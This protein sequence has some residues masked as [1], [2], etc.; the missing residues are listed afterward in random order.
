RDYINQ[1]ADPIDPQIIADR[2]GFVDYVI[3]S[4]SA[5]REKKTVWKSWL[6][7][8]AGHD[9]KKQ[10]AIKR[11]VTFH[12]DPIGCKK[13]LD[14]SNLDL[15][16]W[17]RGLEFLTDLEELDLS[18]NLISK[19]PQ[20]INQLINLGGLDL[21][22]NRLH[23]LPNA[24]GELTFLKILDLCDNPITELPDE[25]A[26]LAH[27]EYLSLVNTE[28]TDLPIHLSLLK[29][30]EIIVN[31]DLLFT[32]ASRKHPVGFLFLPK[33]CEVS[34]SE[35]K[36]IITE[37]IGLWS[38]DWIASS[39]AAT[40]FG[41]LAQLALNIRISVIDESRH[42]ARRLDRASDIVNEIYITAL[43]RH[44]NI[45]R[46]SHSGSR[47]PLNDI[48]KLIN[49]PKFDRLSDSAI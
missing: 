4:S 35:M 2:I 41:A 37:G 16:E 21:K 11:I 28:I 40:L 23:E 38:R 33:E 32:I 3:T 1:L 12:D 30:T 24:I 5:S 43:A 42:E 36:S 26:N 7:D 13:K 19:I 20:S 15:T 25:I 34:E 27:L 8:W 22:K 45:F 9:L 18:N 6:Y 48:T 44:A 39:E 10:E 14:L 46:G 17:P 31:Q 49:H 47:T 29:N